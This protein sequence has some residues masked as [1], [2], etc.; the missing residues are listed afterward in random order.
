MHCDADQ[1]RPYACKITTEVFG[2][3]CSTSELRSVR[4][5]FASVD[6]DSQS[7]SRSSIA[8]PVSPTIMTRT[9]LSHY[10]I[11]TGGWKAIEGAFSAP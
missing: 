6:V 8:C 1:G 5:A 10:H 7:V 11:A 9:S 2:A 4:L 3:I